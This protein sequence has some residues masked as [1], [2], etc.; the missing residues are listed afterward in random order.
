MNLIK[1]LF[2][3]FCACVLAFTSPANASPDSFIDM[4]EEPVGM[5]ATHL[6]LL[7]TSTDNLGYYEAL[8]AEIFL[9]VQDLQSGG[10]EVI[11]IDKFVHSSDYS[12]DGELTGYS[13][14]RDA[15]I[16]PVDPASVLRARG[17][18][19]WVAIHRPTGFEALATITMG[20]QAIEV[21][22]GG[23]TPLRLSREAIQAK[24]TRMGR[25]MADNVADHPRSSSMTTKQHFE[26]REVTAAQ[27]HSAELLDYWMLGQRNRPHL[28]R[29]HCAYDEDSETTSVVM[30]LPAVE[31]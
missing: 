5:S 17:A 29:V 2:A 21:Q 26:G 13:I 18:L 1:A 9:V 16:E 10:E 27:C 8:R 31:R 22:I 11:V 20:E 3:A 24:L 30:R 4:H 23:N 28:L 19:P 14:K 6:F 12:D 25:F 15:G 7:R